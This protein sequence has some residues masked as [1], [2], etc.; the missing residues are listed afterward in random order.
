MLNRLI[1]RFKLGQDDGSTEEVEKHNITDLE[2][3]ED[4]DQSKY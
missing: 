3:Y 4:D 1:D 2:S